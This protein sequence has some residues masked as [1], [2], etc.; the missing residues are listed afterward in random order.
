MRNYFRKKTFPNISVIWAIVLYNSLLKMNY[1]YYQF[2]TQESFS[3]SEAV[4]RKCSI[5]KLRI[6]FCQSS[7]ATLL[8][9]RFG[10]RW[11]SVNLSVNLKNLSCR[12]PAN[13][14]FWILH[15]FM[16]LTPQFI[17]S[18]GTV[19]KGIIIFWMY[20]AEFQHRRTIAKKIIRFKNATF[21]YVFFRRAW[22]EIV[23]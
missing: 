7:L 19:R 6:R 8:K 3:F 14:W 12:T 16:C 23:L 4:A 11:I 22:L 17:S 2:W 10:H 15:G 21:R 9:K 18:S 13:G 5:K 1:L 20:S